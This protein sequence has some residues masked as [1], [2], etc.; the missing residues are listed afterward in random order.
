MIRTRRETRRR[1][2]PSLVGCL[3]IAAL[4][5]PAG[6]A[7]RSAPEPAPPLP[8]SEPELRAAIA[9]DRE[10]L[11][12]LVSRRDEGEKVPLPENSEF[13]EIAERLPRLQAALEELEAQEPDFES[14]PSDP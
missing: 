11:K 10:R 1:S 8:S 2:R 12:E 5:A 9:Q 13:M 7:S 6:C 3:L 14:R 4:L